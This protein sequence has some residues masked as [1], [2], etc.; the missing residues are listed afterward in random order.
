MLPANP[1]HVL[2][3]YDTGLFFMT[4]LQQF[5]RCFDRE[6]QTLAYPGIQTGYHF[7]RI[8]NW[9]GFNN[10]NIYFIRFKPSLEIV[11]ETITE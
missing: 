10:N 1:Q 3:G 7:Q 9:S 8:N 11:R 2:L 6:I 4:A 5:G